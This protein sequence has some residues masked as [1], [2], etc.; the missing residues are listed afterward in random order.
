MPVLPIPM[1]I[2]LLL[3]G[4]L[5][6]RFVARETHFTILALMGFC[7]LQGAVIALVQHYGFTALRP[8]QAINATII[9]P[10]AWVAFVTAAGGDMRPN[11]MALHLLGPLSAIVCLFVF[12]D[13]LDVLIPLSF[14]CYGVAMLVHLWRGEDTLLHSRLDSGAASVFAWRII[15][16]SLISSALCDIA[17]VYA[18]AIGVKSVALWIPSFV[19][20]LSLLSLG[21]LGLSQAT[22]SRR[23]LENDIL[24]EADI[25]RDQAIIANLDLYLVA[26][27]PFLDPDLTLARLARKL[28]VPSKQ[29]SSAINRSKTENVSRFI[30]HHRIDYACGLMAQ[31]KSVTTAMYDSGFNTKSNFNREFSRIKGMSPRDWISKHA[32]L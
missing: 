10:I 8:L 18:I 1:I 11:K 21:I 16:I 24:L 3:C 12:S 2:A 22:A 5:V 6:Q 9:P 14:I 4:F 26:H 7:A 25:E 32:S 30:N 13:F 19:S 20:S 31:G 29:L 23:E 27:K 15:G 17:I 28:L